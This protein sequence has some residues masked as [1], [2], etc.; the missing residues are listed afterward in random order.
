MVGET[1]LSVRV[2]PRSPRDEIVGR[3]DDGRVKIRVA[4]PPVDG[5]ANLRLI[6]F[7]ADRLGVSRSSIRLVRGANS[8]NKVIAIATLSPDEVTRRLGV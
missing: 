1:T 7:L 4:A 6:R 3:L 5:R 8:L 2:Q